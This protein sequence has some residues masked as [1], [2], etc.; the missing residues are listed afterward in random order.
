MDAN[1]Q[2]A[3]AMAIEVRRFRAVLEAESRTMTL[4]HL[5]EYLLEHSTEARAPKEIEIALAVFGKNSG[6]DTSQDSVVRVQVY[7]LRTRLERY[8]SDRSGPRLV[9]PKGQ[10]R[11]ILI[12][13]PAALE[14][15]APARHGGLFWRYTAAGVALNA[16]LWGCFLVIKQ[17][18]QA[19]AKAAPA[20][21][22]R[23]IALAKRPPLVVAGDSYLMVQSD[24]GT[25]IRRMIMRTN[26]QSELDMDRYIAKRPSGYQKLHNLYLNYMSTNTAAAVWN[27]L[28]EI[29]DMRRD[30]AVPDVT[31]VS[32]LS[33][34]RI[35]TNDILYLGRIDEM[36]A[37]RPLLSDLSS[38]KF[39]TVSGTITDRKSGRRFAPKTLALLED[40]A[41]DGA[42]S[43]SGVDYGY[44]ASFP[45]SSG[46]KIFIIAGVQDTAFPQMIKVLSDSTQLEHLARQTG[47]AGAF[48]ALY[49]VQSYGNLRFE[50]KLLFVRPV[51]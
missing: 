33:Q 11:I 8:Y 49:Q 13:S 1:D 16:I 12:D 43:A 25:D 17:P 48:E 32:R 50:A 15:G 46:N 42:G 28:S 31:P 23:P 41:G 5:F 29:S 24:D 20:G 9:I 35:N 44:I 10:Y 51:A 4:L 14:D 34:Q 18:S 37:L 19:V 38:L 26:V 36:G 40:D 7:R 3:S 45:G 6:F 21:F 2:S 30:N 39:D 22:W 47:K 27:V